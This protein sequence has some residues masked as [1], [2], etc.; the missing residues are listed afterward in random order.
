MWNRLSGDRLISTQSIPTRLFC[1][2]IPP[3]SPTLSSP[4]PPGCPNLSIVVLYGRPGTFGRPTCRWPLIVGPSSSAHRRARS[5]RRHCHRHI[6]KPL[7][8]P[9]ERTLQPSSAVLSAIVIIDPF[10]VAKV[11]GGD[12][13]VDRRDI[14]YFCV[15]S[16]LAREEFCPFGTTHTYSY[17]RTKIKGA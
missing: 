15:L 16:E 2:P 8:P 9:T 13:C 10:V 7:T 12:L 3:N 6:R 14:V 11:C 1:H 17:R 5:R 4:P